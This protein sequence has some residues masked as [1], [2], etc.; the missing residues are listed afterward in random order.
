M[1]INDRLTWYELRTT[2]GIAYAHWTNDRQEISRDLFHFPTL[3]KI[4]NVTADEITATVTV[5]DAYGHTVFM[6]ITTDRDPGAARVRYTVV[7]MPSHTR[8]WEITGNPRWLDQ[9]NW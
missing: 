6:A 4:H 5:Q 2:L 7:L 1:K 9:Y 3:L 8:L